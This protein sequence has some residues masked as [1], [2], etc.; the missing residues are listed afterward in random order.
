MNHPLNRR[1]FVKAAGVG[2]G[3]LGVLANSSLTVRA[4]SA[5]MRSVRRPRRWVGPAYWANRLQD[6]QWR[7]GRIECTCTQPDQRLR[8]AARTTEQ[9]IDR[10]GGYTATLDV[11]FYSRPA[12]RGFAGLLLGI[13][14]GQLDW[15]AQGNVFG[16]GGKGGGLGCVVQTDGRLAFIRNTEENQRNPRPVPG[17]VHERDASFRPGTKPI[18][19]N[20]RVERQGNTCTVHAEAR[21]G[22]K[23]VGA[24]KL[25]RVPIEQVIGGV[26]LFTDHGGAPKQPT[27]A[28]FGDLQLDGE[29]VE[30]HPDRLSGPVAGVQYTVGSHGLILTAQMM[31]TGGTADDQPLDL[32][33][34]RFEYRRQ[35]DDG[36][37]T[38]GPAARIDVP[39]HVAKFRLPDWER[40]SSWDIRVVP[41][42]PGGKPVEPHYFYTGEVPAEPDA[43][44]PLKIALFHCP[45]MVGWGNN[46]DYQ[47]RSIES[48][49]ERFTSKNLILPARR[50]QDQIEKEKKPDLLV[51]TGDQIYEGIPSRPDMGRNRSPKSD[52]YLY[53]WI[54]F[55][56]TFG[57]LTR[58]RP[59]VTIPDDHDHFLPNIWGWEGRA[60]R[61]KPGTKGY[62]R[63]HGW[64]YSVEFYNLVIDTQTGHLPDPVDRRPM[65]RGLKKYFTRLDY[66]GTSFAIIEGRTFKTPPYPEFRADE[67]KAE[68]LG[69]GQERFIHEWAESLDPETPRIVISQTVFVNPMTTAQGVIH[70]GGTDSNG[71]PKPGRDRAIAAM[72]EAG[73]VLLGGDIHNAVLIKHGLTG[74]EDGPYQYI[75]CA[76]GQF[77]QRWWEPKQPGGDR[78]PGDPP[79]TGRFVDGGGNPFRMIACTN[80][81][82]TFAQ[83]AAAKFIMGRVL[84]DPGLTRSGYGMVTVDRQ[85]RTI[86]FDHWDRD[87]DPPEQF[88]GWPVRIPLPKPG[89]AGL[90]THQP[91]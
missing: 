91:L 7:D 35:G 82:I 78:T 53:K 32:P 64:T 40:T 2:V 41:L 70:K 21:A 22:S 56:R 6:W 47:A 69:R 36:P 12:G 51:F 85:Q 29:M 33:A 25:D 76:F 31:P 50:A 38:R 75:P 19:L 81:K 58:R 63:D 30:R 37:W 20:L 88:V 13:G 45:R 68:L 90:E 23:V 42:L 14:A 72:K 84:I 79:F 48:P 44:L 59:T 27:L 71:W 61:G 5:L 73:A 87:A 34:A 11:G 49:F 86:A 43:D 46:R 66:G 1:D 8:V 4:Q 55:L 60:P 65:P 9:I 26:G 54:I 24:T 16:V 89:Y 77:F 17:T 28:H 3:T 10:P 62:K 18:T 52:D 39:S 57:H 15:V 67:S 74:P 80:A 83:A